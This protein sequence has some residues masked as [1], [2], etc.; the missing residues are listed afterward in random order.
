M[1]KA[2]SLV[3]ILFVIMGL[4]PFGFAAESRKA[5][6]WYGQYYDKGKFNSLAGE[7]GILTEKDWKKNGTK[8]GPEEFGNFRRGRAIRFDT[9]GDGALDIHEAA[10]YRQA[11]KQALIKHRKGLPYLY[12]NR[13]WL[14]NHPQIARKLVANNKWL[15]ERPKIAESI[16][17][18][19]KWLNNHPEVAK[20]VYKNRAF[21]NNHPEFAKVLYR[22]RQYLNEHLQRSKKA[23]Q[24]A[25]E[26]P[27]AAK[28]VYSVAKS[29]P[30]RARAAVRHPRR[31]RRILYRHRRR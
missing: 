13:D 12:E 1:K 5:L 14:K 18:N 20:E 8:K 6:E 27:Y 2:I 24:K 23:Y 10:A 19:R 9:D 22:H 30:K 31:A 3:L 21:L 11:E 29:H 28:R 26:H 15:E 25:R 7:D 4:L 16:Y 17:K